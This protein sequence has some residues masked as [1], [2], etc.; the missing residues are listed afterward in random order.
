[1]NNQE[2]LEKAIV[3]AAGF[4]ISI[5]HFA[6]PL[7]KYEWND[8]K[9]YWFLGDVTIPLFEIIYQHSFA[10]A[11]WGEEEL[12]PIN[13]AFNKIIKDGWK[14][15]LQAMVIADDPIKYLGDNI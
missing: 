1:M 12:L 14:R 9:R 6:H 13:Q 3:K 7:Q 2:I 5:P 8:D 4:D 15:H 11:L 10:K